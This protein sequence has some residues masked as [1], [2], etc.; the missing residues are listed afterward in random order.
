VM[1]RGL[2]RFQQ[3]DGLWATVMDQPE[4]YPETSGSAGIACGILMA[5]KRGLLDKSSQEAAN[6]TIDAILLKVL[7]NGEATGVSGGTP[8]MPSIEA[9]NKI[10]CY[11]TLYGQGLVL[12]LLSELYAE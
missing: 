9:Y 12:M 3:A 5:V 6:R 7:P 8:V 11:P 1:M 4:F 10:P 2:I